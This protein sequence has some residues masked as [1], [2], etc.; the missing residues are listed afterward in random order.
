MPLPF[1]RRKDAKINGLI[2]I[3]KSVD[4]R[5]EGVVSVGVEC[6]YQSKKTNFKSDIV[7]I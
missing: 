1:D 7:E 4:G 5:D 6:S 2:V 3:I